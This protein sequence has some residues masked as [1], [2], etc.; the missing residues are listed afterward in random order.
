MKTAF[1]SGFD[2]P[3]RIGPLAVDALMKGGLVPQ[4]ALIPLNAQ[5]NSGDVVYSASPDFPYGLSIGEIKE[6][7]ISSDK[8]F[9]E[10]TLEFAYDINEIRS[11]FIDARIQ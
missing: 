4:V 9:R 1:D 11:V 6:I 8:L 10:A 3:V 7:K 5:I 2:T